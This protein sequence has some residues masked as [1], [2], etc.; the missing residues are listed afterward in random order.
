M[1]AVSDH[2]VLRTTVTVDAE[3]YAG[4]RAL[5]LADDRP[6]TRYVNRVLAAHIAQERERGR[7]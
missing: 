2:S 7:P 1:Q 3:V 5:A 4:I 6:I